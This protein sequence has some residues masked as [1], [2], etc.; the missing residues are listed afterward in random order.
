MLTSQRPACWQ[1]F[2]LI[3]TLHLSYATTPLATA[4][5]DPAPGSS[6]LKFV[7]SP[8][9][10][11][12][13]VKLDAS[14]LSKERSQLTLHVF[15]VQLLPPRAHVSRFAAWTQRQ[16]GLGWASRDPPSTTPI[17]NTW[18]TAPIRPDD[19]SYAGTHSTRTAPA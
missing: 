12:V 8:G 4:Q 13:S 16:R 15:A 11:S 19:A 1:R 3:P 6:E 18:R 9:S 14:K 7:A 17:L 2:P 10:N 5:R